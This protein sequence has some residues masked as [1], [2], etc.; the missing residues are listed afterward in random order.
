LGLGGKNIVADWHILE[1]LRA[2]MTILKDHINRTDPTIELHWNIL[3][4]AASQRVDRMNWR[5]GST[6]LIAAEFRAVMYA[7]SNTYGSEILSLVGWLLEHCPLECRPELDAAMMQYTELSQ[8]LMVKHEPILIRATSV[9]VSSIL[10]EKGEDPTG[11][12]CKLAEVLAKSEHL[13]DGASQIG[14]FELREP[15]P[16]TGLQLF[17]IIDATDDNPPRYRLELH[18]A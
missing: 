5:H 2:G 3:Q 7:I 14:S 12:L 1:F 11:V 16:A 17:R 13:F 18:Q 4:A 6:Y 10:T 8:C 15:L 9:P